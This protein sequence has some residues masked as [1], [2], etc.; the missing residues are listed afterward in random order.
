MNNTNLIRGLFLLA[1]ALIFGVASSMHSLGSVNRPGPGLFPLIVSGMLGVVALVTI[2]RAYFVPAVNM[3]YNF[4]NIAIIIGSLVAF[5]LFSMYVNMIAG[6]VALV[7]FSGLAAKT[8]SFSRN[9][10]IT[11]CLLGVAFVFKSMLGLN[12]PLY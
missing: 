7:F 4:K 11:V 12:L 10:K 2:I 9:A 5:A 6:V 8:Y 3:T 1:I